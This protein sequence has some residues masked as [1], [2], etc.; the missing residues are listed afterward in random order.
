MKGSDS[1]S[2]ICH[3]KILSRKM[4]REPVFWLIHMSTWSR[5]HLNDSI[6]AMAVSQNQRFFVFV[7]EP[8]S[9]RRHPRECYRSDLESARE[10]ADSIVQA[11]YP[12]DC[13]PQLCGPWHKLDS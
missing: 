9:E 11:Y 10:T 13:T 7:R 4:P 1:G 12:H 2:L 5:L 6:K 3:K 8:A